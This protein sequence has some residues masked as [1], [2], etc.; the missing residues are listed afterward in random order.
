MVKIYK[1]YDE[2]RSCGNFPNPP[3]EPLLGYAEGEYEDV[4][5]YAQSLK[6]WK[7]YGKGG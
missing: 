7:T 6:G 3:Y 5:K 1:I 2:D 4:L